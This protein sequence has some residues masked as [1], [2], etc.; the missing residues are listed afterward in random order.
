MKRT[1]FTLVTGGAGVI[2]SHL[3][4]R[5]LAEGRSVGGIDD[6]S[7]RSAQN[8]VSGR[9]HPG[10]RWGPAPV[11]QCVELAEWVGQAETVY[12]LAATV[13]VDRVLESPLWAIQT[14]LHETEAVLQAAS[15]HGAKV[16]LTSSSEVYGK[17]ERELLREDADLN[18]G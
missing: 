2:G 11:S 12:H 1:G 13:G 5:L 8:L 15:Q 14:N 18:I 16:V 4:E 6:L 17:S 10:L 9:N 3:V 7:T